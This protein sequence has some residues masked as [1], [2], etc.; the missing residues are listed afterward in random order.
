MKTKKIY[1]IIFFL[2]VIGLFFHSQFSFCQTDESFYISMTHRLSQGDNLILDE[3]HPTQF[4]SPLL[5]PFYNLFSFVMSSNQ[6]I[7]LYYRVLTLL[8]SAFVCWLFFCEMKRLYNASFSFCAAII[9]LLFARANIAGASYYKLCGTFVILAY[10]LIIKSERKVKPANYILRILTG[11][12]ISFAVLCQP[13]LAVFVILAGIVGFVKKDTRLK[14]LQICLGIIV[15]AGWYILSFLSKG[16]IND[17][18]LG[19]KYVLSDP[20]HQFSFISWLYA[21]ATSHINAN[22]IIAICLVICLT[23]YVV[24]NYKKKRILPR[25]FF[26]FQCLVL[27][28]SIIKPLVKIHNVPCYS[29]LGSFAIA[30]FPFFLYLTLQKKTSCTIALYYIGIIL[31]ISFSLGSNTGYDA[32]LTG[33]HISAAAMILEIGTLQALVLKNQNTGNKKL[34]RLIVNKNSAIVLSCILVLF[35]GVQ[36]TFGFYRDAPIRQMTE[37]IEQGP[38]AG[39]LTTEQHAEEYNSIYNTINSQINDSDN[40]NTKLICSKLLPWVY[41]CSD[42]RCGATSTWVSP[43]SSQMLIDYIDIHNPCAMYVALF[44][45][46]VGS[47]ESCYFNNHHER[48]NMNSQI[49]DGVFYERI[50]REGIIVYKDKQMILYKLKE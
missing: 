25:T 44:T 20:Q 28:L 36:K 19:I 37:R 21:M 11:M 23:G 15:T 2:I 1:P 32:M 34:L 18:L 31:A 3:W 17:Y 50:Q 12:I 42:I 45:E 7:I 14:I 30:S 33:Y 13:Y 6:G 8:F 27:C 40:E 49:I 38:A 4:Y 26:C 39:L 35:T 24:W 22:S 9:L 47:Y 5:L 48:H 43:V 16:T 29:Y 41:L 10:T 46:T